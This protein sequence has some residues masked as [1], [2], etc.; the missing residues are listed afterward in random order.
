MN[1][2]GAAVPERQARYDELA[3]SPVVELF[4]RGRAMRV[5]PVD[6]VA[7]LVARLAEVVALLAGAGQ[8]VDPTLSK[9]TV[10]E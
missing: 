10:G 3:E 6:G 5:C 2:P 7:E 1:A 9:I 4:H 8:W